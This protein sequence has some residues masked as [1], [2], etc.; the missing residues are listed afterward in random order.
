MFWVLKSQEY[1][2][3][4]ADL[5]KQRDYFSRDFFFFG[6]SVQKAQRLKN[7]VVKREV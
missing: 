1:N 5:R 7:P 4:L 2:D 3:I 6:M